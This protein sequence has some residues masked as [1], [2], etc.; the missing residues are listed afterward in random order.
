M[1]YILTFFNSVGGV[2]V[3][4]ARTEFRRDAV[5]HLAGAVQRGAV[6]PGLATHVVL[7]VL[8]VG[9]MV[10]RSALVVK[11]VLHTTEYVTL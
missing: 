8:K 10:Y 6:Q 1:S 4:R 5:L 2:G 11:T 3:D 9:E 7:A